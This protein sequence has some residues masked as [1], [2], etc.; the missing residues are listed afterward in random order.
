MNDETK[1]T[2]EQ[3][4]AAIEGSNGIKTTIANKLHV[5]RDTVDSYLERWATARRAYQSEV[6]KVGDAAEG[7]VFSGIFNRDIDTAKWYLRMKCKD[8]G[9]VE[10]QEVTGADGKPIDTSVRILDYRAAAAAIAARPDED[11]AAPGED[12]SPINGA[13]LG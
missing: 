3:V 10:R 2:L 7:V 4:L 12:Q 13:A 8:R 5:H 9:Y 1:C 6:E 11:N